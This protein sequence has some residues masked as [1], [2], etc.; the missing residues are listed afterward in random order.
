MRKQIDKKWEIHSNNGIR[1]P[2][3]VPGDIT[4]DLF[5]AGLIEDPF[6]G[7]NHNELGWVIDSDF[8]YVTQFDLDEAIWQ[9]D[10]IYLQFN[11][12][13]IFAEIYLNAQLLGKTDNMFLQYEYNIK[14]VVKKVNNRLSVRMISTKRT[15][16][17]I[18]TEDYWGIFNTPR[19]FLRKAQCQF[20][21]DWAPNMPGYGIYKPIWVEGRSKHRINDISYRAY[22][23][24]KLCVSVE[25]NYDVRPLTD[26]YGVPME[27][28][29]EYV[30]EDVLIYKVAT[31]PGE[32]LDTECCV[33][34]EQKVTGTK[35]FANF[36]IDEPE[37][38]WP[39]GYG[40]QPLYS[41]SVELIRK[42]EVLD[43]KQG[44]FAFREVRLEQQPISAERLECKIVVNDVPVFAKG[45]NWV[46]AEC[47]MGN[48]QKEKYEKLLTLAKNGNMNMLRVWGGGLYEHD[49][50]YEICDRLGIMV[51]QD[52]MFACADIPEERPEFVENVKKEITYQIK[53]LR[54]HPSIVL[55]SGGNEKVG[56]LCKQVS[57]GDF[58]MEVILRG[59]IANLDESRPIIKQSPYGMTALGND[60][61]SGD[62]HSSA[63]EA[64]LE[65]GVEKYRDLV[66][67]NVAS[68]VSECAI[69]GPGTLESYKKMFPTDKL[70]PMNEYWDDRLMDNPYA[71]VRI[72]FAERQR[73]FADELYGESSCIEAFISKGMTAHAEALRTEI[74]YARSNKGQTWG[75]M[76][77][78][79]S[80]SWPSGTWSVVDYYCEPKQA[81]YQM[82]HSYEPILA[83]FVQ[84]HDFKTVLCIVN[85]EMC[86]VSG[87]LEYGLKTLGGE[88]CWKK[89]IQIEVPKNGVF[90]EEIKEEFRKQNAYL[91]AKGSLNGRTISTVY[92]YDMWKD[93]QFESDYDYQVAKEDENLVV[94]IKANKFAKGITLRLPENEKYEFSDNYFDL[95]AGAEKKVVIRGQQEVDA[96]NLI[97]T[98]FAKETMC[99]KLI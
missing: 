16:S 66:S 49:E 88:V 75:F 97:V 93:C 29:P 52:M 84:T 45:S 59:L 2:G 42:G 30:K 39:S 99:S 83:T 46:P 32:K 82:K 24:G 31:R 51:W 70:W 56:T 67:R 55:W 34:Y 23:N 90:Q 9:S 10:E 11:G 98:D 60:A 14:D 72:S 25:L 27:I 91:Y 50:F 4:S 5:Q 63:C 38:W 74:E 58:F 26:K 64:S 69:M 21:W 85:D 87:E 65:E 81:Y 79:Y 48:M 68:F 73:R 15:M 96:T 20:G 92:S 12:I 44:T 76:N 18:D 71:A 43:K 40:K 47:F 61:T 22:N 1:I 6:W 62:V 95:D 33:Q 37:L 36:S 3:K 41:Y 7:M 57:H 28:I 86:D 53:R 89:H 35:S 77:W 19:L 13:D 94:T 78:M 80:D 17:A 54:H 8:T